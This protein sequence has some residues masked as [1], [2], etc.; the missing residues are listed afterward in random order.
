M[1]SLT[2]RTAAWTMLLARLCSFVTEQ[3]LCRDPMQ[4]AAFIQLFNT[5]RAMI[6]V[7]LFSAPT[8]FLNFASG[9]ANKG[10]D[11]YAML[12]GFLGADN[13]LMMWTPLT[14]PPEQEAEM[15][16]KFLT[17]ASIFT[18]Q[19]IGRSGRAQ[20]KMTAVVNFDPP[21]TPPKGVSAKLPPLGVLHHYRLE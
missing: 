5:A 11:I 20:A 16:K 17:A 15:L 19:S 18:I 21:W 3:P 10:K 2:T 1:R 6:P 14:I 4:A 9:K 8:D 13:P 12:I 7:A